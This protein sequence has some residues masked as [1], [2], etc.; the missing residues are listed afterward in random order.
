MLYIIHS[1]FVCSV[2][3][4]GN[5]PQAAHTQH[6]AINQIIYDVACIFE[7]RVYAYTFSNIHGVST[8]AVIQTNTIL[9]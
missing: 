7:S 4:F 6:T 1:T 9:Y 8:M 2:T 3:R 5:P